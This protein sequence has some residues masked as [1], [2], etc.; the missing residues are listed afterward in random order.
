MYQWTSKEF[1]TVRGTGSWG[2]RKR[3][4]S[5]SHC[6]TSSRRTSLKRPG[7]S[8]VCCVQ[9]IDRGPEQFETNHWNCLNNQSVYTSRTS[10]TFQTHIFS[11]SL[12]FLETPTVTFILEIGGRLNWS[13]SPLSVLN[14]NSTDSAYPK[15]FSNHFLWYRGRRFPTQGNHKCLAASSW[16]YA[17]RVS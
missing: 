11:E 15:R 7:V 1:S 2:Q 13:T 3:T 6:V 14:T 5:C 8:Y 17:E 10:L 12:D 9:I 4:R 16:F